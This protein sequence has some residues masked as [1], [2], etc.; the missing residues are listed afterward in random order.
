MQLNIEWWTW[1]IWRI[2]LQTLTQGC[3]NKCTLRSGRKTKKPKT[4]GTLLHHSFLEWMFR[5]GYM[6]WYKVDIGT[7]C[8]HMFNSLNI[9][10]ESCSQNFWRNP[11]TQKIMA[12]QKKHGASAKTWRN[13]KNM[14][15]PCEIPSFH[16]RQQLVEWRKWVWSRA[17]TA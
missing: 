9:P 5:I 12:H 10:R 11:K 16:K 17:K 13:W 8:K 14:A 4:H 15:H 1:A 3:R 2:P 7:R 6:I